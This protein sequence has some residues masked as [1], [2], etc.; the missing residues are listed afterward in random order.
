MF[1]NKQA[2]PEEVSDDGLQINLFFP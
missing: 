2:V 1:L